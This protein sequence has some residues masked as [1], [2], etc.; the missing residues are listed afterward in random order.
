MKVADIVGEPLDI[1]HL[2]K[3]KEGRNNKIKKLIDNVGL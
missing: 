2:A 3:N 1:Y